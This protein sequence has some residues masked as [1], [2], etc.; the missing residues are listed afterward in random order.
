MNEDRAPALLIVDVQH[1]FCPGGA[2]AVPE[3]DAV[4]PPLRRLAAKFGALGLPI[5]A[6]RDW[7][8]PDSTHFAENGGQWPVHCVHDTPGA[9]LR[10]DLELPASTM[11]VTTGQTRTDEGYSAMAGEVSGR[12]TMLADLQA[13]KVDHLYVGGLATDYCVKH[14]VLDALH[15]GIGVTVLTDAIRA[16]DLKP[17]D[18]ERALEEMRQAGAEFATSKDVL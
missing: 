10:E 5:Y 7:H 2:L 13:R 15:N 17:G 12:G 11:I 1:D 3:G 18:A 9:R 4:V 14:S 8:P 16:V 6:S